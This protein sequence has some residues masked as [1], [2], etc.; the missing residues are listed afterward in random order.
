[1]ISWAGFKLHLVSYRLEVELG[2]ILSHEKMV[3]VIQRAMEGDTAA[4]EELFKSYWN[5]AY[6]YCYKYLKNKSDAEEVA[7]DAF[8]ALSRSICRLNNPKSFMAYFSRILVNAC[9]NRFKHRKS[10]NNGMALLIDGYVDI[11]PEERMEFLPDVMIS[12]QELR[13]EIIKLIDELP[14]K[15]REVILLHFLQELSQS[16]IASVLDVKPS[17]V[18]NRLFHAKAALKKKLEKQAS[19]GTVYTSIVSVPVVTGILRE[20]MARVATPDIQARAW[21][22]LQGQIQPCSAAEPAN[23]SGPA[24]LCC[25]T[26]A[27]IAAICVIALC[28]NYF[29]YVYPSYDVETPAAQAAAYNVLGEIA[30]LTTQDDFDEFIG[31][32]N[33][34]RLQVSTWVGQE[35]KIEYRLYQQEFCDMVIFTGIRTV[36]DSAKIVYK[37]ALPGTC[38]PQDIAA[39][40]G[41]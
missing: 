2:N 30:V 25:I 14:S 9:H 39:W 22:G 34:Y 16:E 8:F 35:V 27:C 5:L 15:Q 33:F 36:A 11:L 32:Y 21:G 41:E 7:Q 38:P 29:V 31:R 1:M 37:V 28:I 10:K 40:I 24:K 3:P 23:C 26:S 12:R 13:D 4:F 6:F 19:K 18:G 20:E 17:V